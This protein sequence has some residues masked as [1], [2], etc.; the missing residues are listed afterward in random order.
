MKSVKHQG[1]REVD[2]GGVRMQQELSVTASVSIRV[3]ERVSNSDTDRVR[4]SL[5]LTRIVAVTAAGSNPLLSS[6]A[7]LCVSHL[8]FLS[9]CAE[10]SALKGS[11]SETL[12]RPETRKQ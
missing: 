2:G 1:R 10:D 6:H 11:A 9:R 12:S 7:S 4:V 5:S 3:R 8:P